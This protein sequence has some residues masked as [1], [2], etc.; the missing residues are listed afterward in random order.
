[1]QV[2][3]LLIVLLCALA[4]CNNW[5]KEGHRSLEPGRGLS[6]Q[7]ADMNGKNVGYRMFVPHGDPPPGG[8]P[9]I[10]F[11]HGFGE[12]GNDTGKQLKVGLGPQVKKRQKQFPFVVLFPQ[13]GHWTEGADAV[14]LAALDHARTVVP[15]DP[16]RVSVTGMSTGATAAWRVAGARA[17]EVAAV[18]PVAGDSRSDVV[19]E[20]AAND[21]AVWIWH[22]R[23]DPI[24]NAGGSDRMANALR[25][26]GLEVRYTKP[27]SAAHDVWKIAYDDELFYWL[28][29]QRRDSAKRRA[30]DAKV[31]DR[32]DRP[33]S[34]RR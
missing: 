20:L 13:V 1:M 5:I 31:P 19:D 18:V 21:V 30:G 14:A 25:K 16:N 24:V 3:G 12:G 33:S 2:R 28:L 8:Y 7:T 22:N 32:P 34:L 26:R 15:I 27:F 9:A 6:R 29:Q 17:D 4:G 11:L 23:F 10:L